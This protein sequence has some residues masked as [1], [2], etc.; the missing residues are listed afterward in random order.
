MRNTLESGEPSS[1]HRADHAGVQGLGDGLKI[2]CSI[3]SGDCTIRN[4]Y[5]QPITWFRLR[6]KKKNNFCNCTCFVNSSELSYRFSLKFGKKAGSALLLYVQYHSF[7]Q[8]CIK[9]LKSCSYFIVQVMVARSL[10]KSSKLIMMSA[11]WV[12][13]AFS[14]FLERSGL[15]QRLSLWR[16]LLS[17]ALAPKPSVS[18]SCE[19]GHA[20]IV[21]ET[22][23]PVPAW[24]WMFRSEEIIR[25]EDGHVMSVWLKWG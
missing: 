10:C 17:D 1:G 2:K 19:T 16:W 6:L 15:G 22:T 20:L 18:L 25:S 5:N 11:T 8:T 12:R 21:A 9:N 4:C 14:A 7:S 13:A 23:V 24:H 3:Y